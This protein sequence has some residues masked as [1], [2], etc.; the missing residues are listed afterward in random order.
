MNMDS[1]FIS[2]YV[3][4]FTP[5][6]K[7]NVTGELIDTEVIRIKRSSFLEKYNKKEWVVYRLVSVD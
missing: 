4:D 6:P 7:D 5:C 1:G 2:V 3:D